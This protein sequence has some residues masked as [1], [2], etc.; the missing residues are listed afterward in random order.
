MFT[1]N[2]NEFP[3]QGGWM[4][5]QVQTGWSNPLAMVGYKASVDAIVKHRK[6]N[7]AITTKFQLSTD[8]D[9]VGNELVEFNRLRLGIAPETPSFP[10]A[11]RSLLEAGAAVGDDLKTAARGTAVVLDWLMSGGKP[12]DQAT[13]NER[14]SVCVACPHNQEGKWFTVAPA[15]II[16]TTLSAR[17]DLKLETPHDSQLKSCDICKCLNRLKPWVPIEHIK[18]KTSADVMARFPDSCWIKKEIAVL[19]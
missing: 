13:A 12:V 18:N 5:R 19:T 9:R 14:A 2:R 1:T 4:F 7:P 10:S 16:R 17:S 8:P 3:N 15:E 11:R 6:A